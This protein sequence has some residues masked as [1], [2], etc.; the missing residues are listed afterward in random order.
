MVIDHL[1]KPKIKDQKIDIKGKGK[2]TNGGKGPSNPAGK[3]KG[4]DSHYGPG[5][6]GGKKDGKGGKVQAHNVEIADCSRCTQERISKGTSVVP[7]S[8]S[9]KHSLNDCP[10]QTNAFAEALMSLIEKRIPPRP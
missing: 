4:K 1:S 6:P 10:R 2:G 8:E 5:A 9:L 7:E 3:G